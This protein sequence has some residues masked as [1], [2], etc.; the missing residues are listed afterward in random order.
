M[1]DRFIKLIATACLLLATAAN[2][3]SQALRQAPA[4]CEALPSSVKVD[5]YGDL[6]P[7]EEGAR[8]DKLVAALKGEDED[9]KAF[10][11]AY[12]GR[13]ARR[14]EAW[15]R[16][17]RAKEYLIEKSNSYNTRINALDCGHREGPAT[18]LWIT[19]AG[20][21]PPPCSPTVEPGEAQV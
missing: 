2:P 16:A 4:G 13:G 10:I 12:A 11:I 15:A 8:L 17:D 3:F 14:G 21:A 1:N 9:T 20:A 18:E 19:R 7:F 6:K 5:E